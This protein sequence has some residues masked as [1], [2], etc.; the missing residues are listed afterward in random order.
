MYV[1]MYV[2]M[3]IKSHFHVLLFTQDNFGIYSIYHTCLS[4][5]IWLQSRV[6][7][8][9]I[10]KIVCLTFTQKLEQNASRF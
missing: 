8:Y 7:H 5:T 2:C 6:L 1:C 3:L 4:S 10:D 9:F